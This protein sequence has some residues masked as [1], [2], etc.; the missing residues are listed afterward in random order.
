MTRTG[1]KL[2]LRVKFD[3]RGNT[4]YYSWMIDRYTK[5]CTESVTGAK[6]EC[7]FAGDVS[8]SRPTSPGAKI[9]GKFPRLRFAAH[10]MIGDA[11]LVFAPK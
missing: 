3:H 5:S 11:E 4:N 8:Q 9:T 6:F 1:D 10:N 2:K 7:W